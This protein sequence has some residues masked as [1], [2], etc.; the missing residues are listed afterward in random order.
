MNERERMCLH[1]ANISSAKENRSEVDVGIS[2]CSPS[3]ELSLAPI[4]K[5]EQLQ[6]VGEALS[7]HDFSPD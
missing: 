6:S 5:A 2:G 4:F 1:R 7:H 3:R